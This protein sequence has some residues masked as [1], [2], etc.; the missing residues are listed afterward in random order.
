MKFEIPV[1]ETQKYVLKTTTGFRGLPLILS[2]RDILFNKD[3]YIELPEAELPSWKLSLLKRRREVE[4]LQMQNLKEIQNF[5]EARRP[6]YDKSSI[7]RN[8]GEAVLAFRSELSLDERTEL[9]KLHEENWKLFKEKEKI[10]FREE[11]VYKR[12]YSKLIGI[13]GLARIID[14]DPYT[15][16]DYCQRIIPPENLLAVRAVVNSDIFSKDI[17]EEDRRVLAYIDKETQRVNNSKI[18]RH[19]PTFSVSHVSLALGITDIESVQESLYR[20][21]GLLCHLYLPQHPAYFSSGETTSIYL[22]KW[23]IPR[24]RMPLVQEVLI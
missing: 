22:D 15:P 19:N 24:K 9:D 2:E 6:L 1:T 12:Q 23:F 18:I 21:T 10:A 13:V 5:F 7:G 4:E 16:E 17:T 20:L 11:I 3:R 14:D 8:R